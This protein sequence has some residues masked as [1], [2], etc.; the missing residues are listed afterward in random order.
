MS[1]NWNGLLTWKAANSGVHL[2]CCVWQ[3]VVA[4]PCGGVAGVFCT[5]LPALALHPPE[6]SL[7]RTS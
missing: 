4:C 3:R 6:W 2:R 5:D 1:T 7:I